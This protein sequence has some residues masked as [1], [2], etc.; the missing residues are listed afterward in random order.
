LQLQYALYILAMLCTNS[1]F[2]EERCDVAVF[3]VL[4]IM[5][6]NSADF[7]ILKRDSGKVTLEC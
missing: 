6:Y 3:L 2:V 5:D 1:S 4:H 7:N